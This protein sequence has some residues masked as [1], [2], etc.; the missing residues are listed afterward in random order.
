MLSKTKNVIPDSKRHRPESPEERLALYDQ[1]HKIP[2][3]PPCDV[4]PWRKYPDEVQGCDNCG[5][6]YMGIYVA[7]NYYQ[8]AMGYWPFKGQEAEH[9]KMLLNNAMDLLENIRQPNENQKTEESK[10]AA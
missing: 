6:G 9:A 8:R 3:Q 7:V 5:C 2:V 1:L 4:C 10:D